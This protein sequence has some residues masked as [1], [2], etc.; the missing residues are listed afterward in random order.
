MLLLN[1]EVAGKLHTFMN[2]EGGDS[3]SLFY[4]SLSC[5]TITMGNTSGFFGMNF[6]LAGANANSHIH[7][8]LVNRRFPI[9]SFPSLHKKSLTKEGVSQ[10]DGNTLGLRVV[11]QSSL[12]KLAT[13]SRLLVSSEW[14]LVVKHVILVDPDGTGTEL[15][16]DTDGSVQVLCVDSSGKTICGVVAS[17]DDLL[18]GL[19]LG[20]GADGAEDLFLHDLHVLSDIGEDSGLDEVSLVTVTLATSD[21][22][23]AFLLSF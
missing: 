2:D 5:W 4:M 17:L 19:E 10:T 16:G 3:C 22:G 23:R 21:N 15:V 18:F 13:N 11:G 14:D 20:D 8:D 1:L 12:T 6:W 9:H 7:V